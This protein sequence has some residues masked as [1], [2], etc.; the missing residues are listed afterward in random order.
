MV[1]SISDC[2]DCSGRSALDFKVV[3]HFAYVG[4][5]AADVAAAGVVAVETVAIAAVVAVD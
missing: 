1:A 5:A 2:F 3:P 4:V